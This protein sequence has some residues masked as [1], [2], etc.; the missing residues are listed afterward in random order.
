MV[1][2]GAA[3]LLAA[4]LMALL[5][6][7]SRAQ[8]PPGKRPLI[9][10]FAASYLP[11][12][13]PPVA[14]EEAASPAVDP[15]ILAMRA[16]RERLVRSGAVDALAYQ[17]D[18][19]IFLRA[20]AENKLRVNAENPSPADRFALG[21]AVGA[22]QILVV[23]LEKEKEGGVRIDGEA[24]EIATRRAWRD[25]GRARIERKTVS[26]GAPPGGAP[27]DDEVLSAASTL[28]GKFLS[29][30]LGALTRATGPILPASPTDTPAAAPAAPRDVE[31]EAQSA[32][33]RGRKLLAD[34]DAA[35]AVVALNRAVNLSPR[36][37]APRAA[38]VRAYLA[39]GRSSDAVAEA[40]R[41]LDLVGSGEGQIELT[42]LLA[43]ALAGSGDTTAAA[44]T[45]GQIIEARPGARTVWARVALAD[46]L[47]A[48]DRA[49]EAELQ[50]RAA[51]KF[52]PGNAEVAQ[53]LARLR[54][55][56]D[57]YAGAV[58]ELAE[59]QIDPGVRRTLLGEIFDGGVLG[60]AA[61][62]GRARAAF[63]AGQ[64]TRE[65]LH[66][67]TAAKS[68]RAAGLLTL[69]RSAA[70]AEE[71]AG[72]DLLAHRHRVLAGS[73]LVQALSSVLA[74]V[75]SRD[76]ASA[77]RADLLLG[78]ARREIAE[79]QQSAP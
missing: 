3:T 17:P 70:P 21:K 52:E 54:A 28:V 67:A 59:T 74:F 55:A 42:R 30:P 43:Q 1:R 63:E 5:C 19:P 45:Y 75:Q 76:A 68:A 2:R 8:M 38:L 34:G 15:P 33:E 9:V 25:N 61:E 78:E 57:D 51:R 6:A 79:A 18:A 64:I 60:L 32:L 58:E 39:A 10:V 69:I 49:P 41:A 72:A 46:L 36:A 31:A 35:G 26:L 20:A 44:A 11:E 29:G 7:A 22:L 27:F 62:M 4:T 65:A 77:A 73:L 40:H 24:V 12:P 23:S 56:R 66:Q 71:P 48:Q 13:K 50:L 53:R 37:P 16:V 14:L 47:L